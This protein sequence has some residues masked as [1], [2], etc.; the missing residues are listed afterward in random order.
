MLL[1]KKDRDLK[2][3]N[4]EDISERHE[5]LKEIRQLME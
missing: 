2:Y 1:I 5:A 3:I 4:E